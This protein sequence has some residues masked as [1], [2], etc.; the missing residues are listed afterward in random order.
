M[1]ATNSPLLKILSVTCD[2]ASCNDVMVEE[3]AKKVP[4][5]SIVNHTRCFLHIVNLCAKSIIKQFDVPKKQED[6]HLDDAAKELQD[7][8]MNTMDQDLQDLAGDLELE[9]RLATEAMAQ[10]MIDGVAIEA[11]KEPDDDVDS[12]V[13]E[14]VALSPSEWEELEEN[15]QPVK[16]VLVKVSSSNN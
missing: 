13:D 2:N 16:L 6:E 15:I 9:E 11:G 3:L 12:W 10:Q 8:N 14:M 1:D 5:F 7:L 4:D